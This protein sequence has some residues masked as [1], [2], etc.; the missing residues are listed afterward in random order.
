MMIAKVISNSNNN[1]NSNSNS[2][3]NA[4]NE[5]VAAA[6]TTRIRILTTLIMKGFRLEAGCNFS[7]APVHNH[8]SRCIYI[9]YNTSWYILFFEFFLSITVNNISYHITSYSIV[10]YNNS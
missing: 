7:S 6:T 10:S 3:N 9:Y 5:A 2:N 8:S 1:N 4:N